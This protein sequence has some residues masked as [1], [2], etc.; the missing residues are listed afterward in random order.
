MQA[1]EACMLYYF[2][3]FHFFES[4]GAEFGAVEKGKAGKNTIFCDKTRKS[5]FFLEKK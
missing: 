4:G 1:R 3:I 2:H 5:D